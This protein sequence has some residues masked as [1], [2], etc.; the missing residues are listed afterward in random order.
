MVGWVGLLGSVACASDDNPKAS[1]SETLASALAEALVTACPL[2]DADDADAR[3]DC[4]EALANVKVLREQVKAPLLWG[5][6]KTA[7]VYDL[8]QSN[9]T[10]FDPYV[11]RRLYLSTFSFTK[12]HEVVTDGPRTVLRIGVQFRNELDPGDYPYPFWHSATKWQSYERAQEL[13][14]II[15]DGTLRGVLRSNEQDEARP[16]TEREFDGQWVWQSERGSEPRVTL[17]SWLFSANNPHIE[18]LDSAYR[19]FEAAQR[20]QA[21]TTCHA[22]S[23]PSAANP[24]AMLSYP[25]QALSKRHDIVRE[26]DDNAMPPAAGESKSGI[27]DAAYRDDLKRLAETF[28]EIGDLALAFEGEPKR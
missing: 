12:E 3:T 26:L 21:C 20:E 1:G 18:D 8:T 6:Q 11:Y 14:F 24:L 16:H 22:P 13:L 10:A 5:A 7:G 23:N 9:T 4:A 17:Y 19:D 2:A 15:E 25:N 28:A 27:A